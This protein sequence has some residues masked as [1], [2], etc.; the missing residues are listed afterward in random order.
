MYI[1]LSEAVS[2]LYYQ[3]F[4]NFKLDLRFFIS[5]IWGNRKIVQWGRV[6]KKKG[7]GLK[8]LKLISRGGWNRGGSRTNP[9]EHYGSILYSPFPF[10]N[11]ATD[12]YAFSECCIAIQLLYF[13][14]GVLSREPYNLYNILAWIEV[15]MNSENI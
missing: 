7:R 1:S 13:F 8:I 14:F 11:T 4:Q 10:I 6:A 12:C 2:W 5:T 15:I 9:G 3:N